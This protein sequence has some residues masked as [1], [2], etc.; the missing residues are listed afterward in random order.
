MSRADVG[1]P[2]EQHLAHRRSVFFFLALSTSI[3][4][5]GLGCLAGP[6]AELAPGPRTQSVPR[7]PSFQLLATEGDTCIRVGYFAVFEV[8]V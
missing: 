3:A 5:R 2:T 8:Q 4:R 7:E 1:P 6:L